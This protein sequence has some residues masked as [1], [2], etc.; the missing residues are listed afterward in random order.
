[1]KRHEADGTSSHGTGDVNLAAAVMALGAPLDPL[2]PCTVIHADNGKSYGRF[3]LLPVSA[4]GKYE[5]L[6]LLQFWD[7]PRT[8]VPATHPFGWVMDFIQARPGDRMTADEWMDHAHDYLAGIGEIGP[9]PKNY[10][11][12]PDSIAKLPESLSSYLFAFVHCRALCLDLFR[13]AK[14]QVYMRKHG[15]AIIDTNLPK[16]IRNNLIARL[17]G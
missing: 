4:C 8:T 2:Q 3:F 9:H 15:S 7:A 12:I 14:Q 17:D 10:A 6:K 13:R 16:Q 1:M 11:A 5:T